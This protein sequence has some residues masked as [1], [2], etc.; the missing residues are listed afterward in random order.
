MLNTL[1]T[2]TLQF[3]PGNTVPVIFFHLPLSLIL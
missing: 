2:V 1:S 3:N